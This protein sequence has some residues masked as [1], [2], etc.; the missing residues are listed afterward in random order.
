MSDD[1]A[2][3]CKVVLLGESGVG[4]T[5]II[6]R[7]IN[8][9]FE[10]NIMSTTGASYAGK[11]MSFD[12]LNGQSIKFEIW[13]TAG[14]EKYRAL[15]KIFYKDAGVAILVYDITRKDSFDE[16]KNYWYNQIKD[17]ARKNISKII[18]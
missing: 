4:K 2:K 11:T 16:I 18:I 8:N 5:C 3:T 14:Q 15:T 12:E 10:D 13:D 7:F 9:T 1:N 17:F 6:A